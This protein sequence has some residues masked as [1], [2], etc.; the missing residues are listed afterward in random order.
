MSRLLDPVRARI[1]RV[2]I[3]AQQR[4]AHDRADRHADN[5]V[6]A[7]STIKDAV[8]IGTG[9]NARHALTDTQRLYSIRSSIRRCGQG[10]HRCGGALCARCAGDRVG[11]QRRDLYA[12]T[13]HSTG[14]MLSW[15]ATIASS[16]DVAV[17]RQWADLIAL[18]QATTR[19]GWLSRRHVVG[20]VRTIEPEHGP[21]GWHVHAHYLLVFQNELTPAEVERFQAELL[22]RYL[23]EAHR[24]GIRATA[25]GQD[26]ARTRS[27]TA[28]TKYLTKGRI[29]RGN[30]DVLS[31]LWSAVDDGDADALDLV[32]DL[33]A[34]AFRR[35]LWTPT[36]VCKLPEY[37]GLDFDE[38]L[39]RG[40]F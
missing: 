35:R 1:R 30:T 13:S 39:A 31:R 12:A 3:T 37:A 32:H 18:L 9:D 7:L 33:E 38:M 36:G 15:S 16:P 27:A 11:Q 22:D 6:A 40:L 17:R 24:L 26:I 21:D 10:R 8:T 34:G 20:T 4:A 5:L 2:P 29:R 14:T 25:D 19:G 23:A 28:W